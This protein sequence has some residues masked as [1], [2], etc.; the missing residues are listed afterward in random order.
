MTEDRRLKTDDGAQR[1]DEVTKRTKERRAGQSS[2]AVRIEW[3]PDAMRS[4]VGNGGGE[5]PMHTDRH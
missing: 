1:A 5:P 4:V 3:S 2:G